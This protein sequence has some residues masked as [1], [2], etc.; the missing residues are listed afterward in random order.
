MESKERLYISD[1]LVYSVDDLMGIS[2]LLEFAYTSA[3]D[4]GIEMPYEYLHLLS[5]R[6]YGNAK[7]LKNLSARLTGQD[8][9]EG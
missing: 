5:D 6:V 4:G 3:Q 7:K 8:N 9:R 2:Q 1:Q